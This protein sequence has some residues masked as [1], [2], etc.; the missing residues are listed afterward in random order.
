MN[1]DKSAKK[2]KVSERGR[3]KKSPRHL[4]EKKNQK[5]ES[6]KKKKS[7]SASKDKKKSKRS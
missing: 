5:S 2:G 6:K 3:S 4:G 7:P 1:K